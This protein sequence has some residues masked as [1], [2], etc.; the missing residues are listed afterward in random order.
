M[1]IVMVF[2]IRPYT[3]VPQRELQKTVNK[4]LHNQSDKSSLRGQGYNLEIHIYH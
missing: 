4:N 2:Q 3:G 1:F